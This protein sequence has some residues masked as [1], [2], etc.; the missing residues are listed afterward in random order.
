MSTETSA[1]ISEKIKVARNEKR[2][3]LH[4]FSYFKN[5][6]N[7]EAFWWDKNFSKN[8]LFLG[9]VRKSKSLKK[10]LIKSSFFTG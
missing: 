5:I 9:S 8:L 6:A 7:F 3:K 1:F 2:N 10:K 4:V